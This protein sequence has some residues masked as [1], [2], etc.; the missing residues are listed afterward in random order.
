[1][2]RIMHATKMASYFSSVGVLQKDVDRLWDGN[3]QLMATCER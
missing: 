3:V 1:M 2:K